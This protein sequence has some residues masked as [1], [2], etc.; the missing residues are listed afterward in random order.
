MTVDRPRIGLCTDSTAQLPPALVERFRVAVVPVTITY[1][2]APDTV[3]HL[4]HVDH[5]SP[6]DHADHLVEA[7]EGVELDVDEW[8]RH[9]HPAIVAASASAPSPGQFALAIET[10]LDQGC[11]EIVSL[12][13][14]GSTC[15]DPDVPAHA[16]SLNAVRLA[17]HRLG[18]PVRVVELPA[19]G[20]GIGCAAWAAGEAIEAGAGVDEVVACAERAV[21]ALGHLVLTAPLHVLRTGVADPARGEAIRVQRIVRGVVEPWCDADTVLDAVNAMAGAVL[22]WAPRARVAVGHG[23]PDTEP[24]ATALALSVGETAVVDEVLRYRVGPSSSLH[25]GPG[26]VRCFVLPVA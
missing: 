4:A 10:L 8:Y 21:A 3:G 23:H 17:A 6:A 2:G 18:V 19:A 1:L 22:D 9:D 13:A 16:G 12:H 20:F 24:I 11:S 7:L 26:V 15:A 5:A 14:A 25:T